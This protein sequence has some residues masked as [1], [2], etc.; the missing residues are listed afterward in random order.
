VREASL[1]G[2]GQILGGQ[3]RINHQVPS[4]GKDMKSHVKLLTVDEKKKINSDHILTGCNFFRE[5]RFTLCVIRI[6]KNLQRIFFMTLSLFEKEQHWA[7]RSSLF[8]RAKKHFNLRSLQK[9]R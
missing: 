3:L 6:K 7:I 5:R 9:E 2:A 1:E 8:M 4:L